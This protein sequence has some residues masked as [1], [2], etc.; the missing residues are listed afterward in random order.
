VQTDPEVQ[1]NRS[2]A[3]TKPAT[4]GTVLVIRVPL[5]INQGDQVVVNTDNG[6][7]VERVK[8]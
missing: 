4:L 6:E 1:G 2:S 5:F 3:G 7:Y 8:K